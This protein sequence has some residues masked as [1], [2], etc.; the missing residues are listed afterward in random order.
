MQ[1]MSSRIEA[2][3]KQAT[4]V[5]TESVE[6]RLASF[7]AENIEEKNGQQTVT[8]PMTKKDLA[9]YLGTTPETISRKFSEFEEKGLIKQ[10]P[11]KV[12]E[13]LNLDELLLL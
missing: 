1:E 3:E 10:K 8:L 11:K 6:A 9:S 13:V 4:W 7:I 2:S 5:S 12:I